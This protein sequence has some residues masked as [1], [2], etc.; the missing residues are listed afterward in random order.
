MCHYDCLMKWLSADNLSL[1]NPEGIH[2]H[3][4]FHYL[5]WKTHYAYSIVL[6]ICRDLEEIWPR[7]PEAQRLWAQIPAKSQKNEKKKFQAFFHFF[8]H[9]YLVH[10]GY[11]VLH[12]RVWV[13]VQFICFPTIVTCHFKYQKCDQS[14]SLAV[15]YSSN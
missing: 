4:P 10:N 2:G 12:Y 1:I 15:A 6:R 14:I 11:R 5:E 3:D 7:L 9:K 13:S 8:A